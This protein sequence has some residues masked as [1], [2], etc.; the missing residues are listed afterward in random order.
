MFI[1]K[2]FKKSELA[3]HIC[4]PENTLLFD[5]ETSGLSFSGSHVTVIGAG[6]ADGDLFSVIQFFCEHPENEKNVITDFLNLMKNFSN[7]LHFNGNS[8]DIPYIRQK[9]IKYELK[10]PFEGKES[11][12]LFRIACRYKNLLRLKGLKQKEIEKQCRLERKDTIS[13]ADCI[14]AYKK[15]LSTGDENA[16]NLLLL[17]NEDDILGLFLLHGFYSYQLFQEHENIIPESSEIIDED[18]EKYHVIRFILKPH[19][20][21]PVHS[22]GSYYNLE[23]KENRGVLIIKGLFC[24]RNYYFNDHKDYFYLPSEDIAI[25]KSVGIYVD[26][27]MRRQASRENC[28]EKKTDYF[29]P[30]PDAII[31]PAFRQTYKSSL[32]WY[33]IKHTENLSSETLA[34]LTASFIRYAVTSSRRK[35]PDIKL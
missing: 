26:R 34:L 10:D 2:D 31:N 8:F 6:Y 5:I 21:L 12:D 3:S 33:G 9:C 22:S 20:P 11:I 35:N 17:H 27:K 14:T 1:K 16:K 7:V 23:I 28:R 4:M 30:Q 32:S 25:H 29:F 18:N 15:F 19:I 24:Q 13:G